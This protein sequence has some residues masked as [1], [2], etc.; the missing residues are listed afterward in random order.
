MGQFLTGRGRGRPARSAAR[1]RSG[2][3]SVR[4]GD[5][6]CRTALRRWAGI[7]TR[8]RRA[9][10]FVAAV[11]LRRI[12]SHGKAPSTSL[13]PMSDDSVAERLRGGTGMSNVRVGILDGLG[14]EFSQPR[15][16]AYLSIRRLRRIMH[17]APRT[18]YR[19][20]R[21]VHPPR[22]AIGPAHGAFV[23]RSGTLRASA[24]RTVGLTKFRWRPAG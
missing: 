11:N 22:H 9:P 21:G 10:Q 8:P 5:A 19:F 16:P 7:P 18:A 23:T 17:P 6:H 20:V 15:A 3:R 12:G 13:A 24:L 2:A 1:V 4:A 14:G